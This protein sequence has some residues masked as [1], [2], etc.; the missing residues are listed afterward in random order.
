MTMN[1]IRREWA[2]AVLLLSLLATAPVRGDEAEE[3]AVKAVEKLGGKV[4]R[5]DKAD[6][7]PVVSVDFAGNGLVTDA[8]M[9]NVKGLKN[10]RELNLSGTKITDTGLEELKELKNLRELILDG[11]RVTDAGVED[12]KKALPQ[13]NVS[14]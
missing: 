6:G 7:K 5:D 14:R 9:K 11:T 8:A 13:L 3:K 4:K 2:G 10:L 1:P 12:L